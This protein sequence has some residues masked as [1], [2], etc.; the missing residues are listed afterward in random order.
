M[1]RT[2]ALTFVLALTLTACGG[3]DDNS[4]VPTSTGNENPFA[5]QMLLGI[6]DFP[7]GWVHGNFGA[8]DKDDPFDP[9]ET[10]DAEVIGRAETGYF[11]EEISD[12]FSEHL[13]VFSSEAAAAAGLQNMEQRSACVLER[14]ASG[15]VETDKATFGPGERSDLETLDF[16][17][18]TAAFRVKTVAT[19]K[20]PNA[21]IKEQ[22]LYADF[23][24][25]VVGR[26]GISIFASDSLPYDTDRLG[27][28]VQM[29][30]EKIA[31]GL[32]VSVADP[33]GDASTATAPATTSATRTTRPSAITG[34]ATDRPTADDP[35][36]RG[37]SGTLLDR[38]Q[39]RVV[40]VNFDAEEVV[41][42]ENQFNDPAD[43]G[44]RMVLITLDVTNIGDVPL[45]SF[46]DPIYDLHGEVRTYEQFD[47]SCGLTPKEFEAILESGQSIEGNVCFQVD[48]DE[49]PSD[50]ILS[51]TMY[52]DDFDTQEI[53]LALE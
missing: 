45:D 29:A 31:E 48:E 4:S 40:D 36:A 33:R 18:G 6:D 32:D 13:M 28:A 26:V 53:F 15:Q 17:D 35:I 11:S 46:F 27:N 41:L 38:L 2:V 52:D 20:E 22:D 3:G 16:G 23:L 1:I 14:L 39:A 51:I 19:A 25:V 47:P 43:P 42:A 37:E 34:E 44:M 9:C 24:Y 21:L 30:V 10:A 5:N 49:D 12:S 50:L 7:D 8:D